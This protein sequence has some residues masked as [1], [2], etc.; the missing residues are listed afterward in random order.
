VTSPSGVALRPARDEDAGFLGMMLLEAAFWRSTEQRPPHEEA[1][2][3]PDLRVYL[4]DWGRP[5]DRGVVASK[6]GRPIGAAWYRLF[7]PHESGY[8]FIDTTTPELAIAVA[9]PQ[10]GQ[11][12]GRALLAALLQQALLDGFR[13]VSLS[14]E[15]DNPAK[16]LYESF[17]F[18]TVSD[19]GDDCT[20]LW[21]HPDQ[22]GSAQA[23]P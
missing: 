17:G 9:R 15:V 21:V 10:R 16:A 20:M 23:K 2:R 3:A 18:E 5:G 6:Q 4:D 8:G 14:V 7:A 1:L 11:G 12:I 13:Q 19:R 22:S